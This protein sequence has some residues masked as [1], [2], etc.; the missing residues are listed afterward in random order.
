MVFNAN[1]DAKDWVP[2]INC[3]S[4]IRYNAEQR[5]FI[6]I[7]INLGK[8]ILMQ[9]VIFTISTGSHYIYIYI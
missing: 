3:L 2:D 7:F 1:L 6:S 5:D 9:H 4:F 8:Y